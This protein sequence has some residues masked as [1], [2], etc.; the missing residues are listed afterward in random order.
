M[1]IEEF[2]LLY[3]QVNREQIA[4][5]A[6]CSPALV[7]RWL[8][9]GKTRKKPSEDHKA[10]FDIAHW[11]WTREANEPKLFQELRKIRGEAGF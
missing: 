5:I 7:D 1:D 11:L 6:G 2:R 3:P 10:R 4:R 8:M 9:K